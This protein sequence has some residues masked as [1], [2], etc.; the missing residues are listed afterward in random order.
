MLGG[1]APGVLVRGINAGRE[2]A[3]P[4]SRRFS[5]VSISPRICCSGVS[6]LLESG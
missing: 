1:V 3:G 4:E 5:R 6:G 2:L